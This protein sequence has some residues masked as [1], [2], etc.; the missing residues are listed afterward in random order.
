MCFFMLMLLTA[1]DPNEWTT[2]PSGKPAASTGQPAQAPAAAP[3]A[4]PSSGT[5]VPEAAKP[6]YRDAV[7]AVS[8]GRFQEA[9][10]LLNQLAAE[11]PQVAELYAARCS[12]QLGLKQPVYA[13]ADCT[14]ALKLKPSL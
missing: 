2:F 14:Y 6:R 4:A 5:G 13:E 3:A 7:A 10:V 12:A 1:G 11:Y 9:T 8:G